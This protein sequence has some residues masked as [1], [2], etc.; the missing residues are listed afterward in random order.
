[1]RLEVAVIIFE[2]V[3]ESIDLS[4]SFSLLNLAVSLLVYLFCHLSK[5]VS[6]LIG[7]SQEVFLL[8][9]CL[10]NESISGNQAYCC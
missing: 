9:P 10:T 6:R 3:D 5:T 2:I 7:E 8:F 4:A 1:M